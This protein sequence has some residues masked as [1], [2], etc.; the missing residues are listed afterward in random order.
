M[1]LKKNKR[2]LS[3]IVVTMLLILLTITLVGVIYS[4]IYPLVQN[5]LKKSSIC[6]ELMDSVGISDSE[7]C[8]N[9]TNK[10]LFFMVDIGDTE[11]V[12]R[13]D[14]VISNNE[15]QKSLVLT[16][17][18][19]T[20]I[21]LTSYDSPGSVKLPGKKSGILYNYTWSGSNF[22]PSSIEIIP[23]TEGFTCTGSDVMPQIPLC[24]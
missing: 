7:T 12:E 6:L 18:P 2:A 9:V 3:S 14:I 8:Y 16:K 22:A 5:N 15:T 13:L 23:S 10:K 11:T 19:Q 21:N 17:I 1:I 20:V 4:V 24:S